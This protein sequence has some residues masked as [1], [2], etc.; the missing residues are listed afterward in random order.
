[1]IVTILPGHGIKIQC[2]GENAAFHFTHCRSGERE[3]GGRILLLI[4]SQELRGGI[5]TL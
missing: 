3:G 4:E 2:G 5:V 1:M